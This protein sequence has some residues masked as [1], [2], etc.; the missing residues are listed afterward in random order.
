MEVLVINQRI[1]H[2]YSR[3]SNH[4]LQYAYAPWCWHI[5]QHWP[6]QN[7]PVDKYASTMEPVGEHIGNSVTLRIVAAVSRRVQ[8]RGY[9]TFQPFFDQLLAHCHGEAGCETLQ[10]LLGWTLWKLRAMGNFHV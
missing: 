8:R 1:I 9:D 3:I 5:Y 6:E 4:V 2:R 7:H 10:V